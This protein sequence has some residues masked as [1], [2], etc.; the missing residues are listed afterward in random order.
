[1]LR[2]AR[3]RSLRYLSSDQHRP[4]PYPPIFF[5]VVVL[6]YHIGRRRRRRKK[7]RLKNRL[8]ER[9]NVFSRRCRILELIRNHPAVGASSKALA[10]LA[11]AATAVKQTK[12][13]TVYGTCTTLLQIHQFNG[14]ARLGLS[15]PPTHP[16]SQ[17]VS[18]WYSNGL[19]FFLLLPS[20]S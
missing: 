4:T 7:K 8:T 19:F 10:R 20:S 12:Q 5:V 18:H 13:A 17:S 1:M 16:P 14:A 11:A 15:S 3:A 6:V 2:D 9:W